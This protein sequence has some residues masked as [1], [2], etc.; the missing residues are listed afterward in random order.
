MCRCHDF[1]ECSGCGHALN[2]RGFLKGCGAVAASAAGLTAAVSRAAETNDKKVRV[3]LVFLA[4]EGSSWPYPS[5]DCATRRKEVTACL[6]AGCAGIEFVP[7]VVSEPAEVQKAVSMKDDVDGYLVYMMTLTWPLQRTLAPIGQVGKPMLVA[8]EV[9]GC[10]GAFLVG[11][12]AFERQKISAA[13]VSTTQLDDLVTVARVFAD[14]KKSGTT[15]AA[16]ARK[17][18]EEYRRTFPSAG[19]EQCLEDKVALTDIAECLKRFRE[20]RFLIVGSGT[21]GTEREFLGAKAIYVGF[22]EF[23]A[24][25]EKADR[26]EAREWAARWSKQAVSLVPGD[27]AEPSRPEAEAID[28]AG[29]VYLATL[30]LLQKYGT[31]TVTMN[32]LG[33]F[34]AGKLPSYPCLGFKELLDNGGHGVCEAM[35]DDTLSMLMARILTGRPGFVSDPA[36]DTSK[37]RVI[38][39]HCVGTTKVFGPQGATNGFRIRTLHNRDPRG[40]CAESL[41]PAGYMTTTFRTNA[42][43]KQLV[44]HQAKSLGALDTEHGCRTKLQGEVRGDIE[45]LFHQWDQFGWHRVTVFGDVQEPMAEFGKALGLEVIREA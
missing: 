29:G 30:A 35:P 3:A 26:D 8:D 39:A 19:P 2:R 16:F 7:V 20:S 10:S 6:E 43:R 18:E 38:Y 11:T 28:K 44:I 21:P 22:E 42:A 15:A 9:L 24:L 33:G 40:A 32:C 13:M 41:M 1:G 25:Y 17:C 34:A 37:N 5:Y 36:L 45:K 23:Q 12:S 31:D 27:Y 4:K 14:I